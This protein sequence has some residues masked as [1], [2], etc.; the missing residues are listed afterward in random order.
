MAGVGRKSLLEGGGK[1]AHRYS[2][3]NQRRLPCAGKGGGSDLATTREGSA[4]KS[5]TKMKIV[6][7]LGND[8]RRQASQQQ[9]IA[10]SLPSALDENSGGRENS[11]AKEGGK[12]NQYKIHNR[13]ISRH[14]SPRI[15]KG[16]NR[17]ML[18]MKISGALR[19]PFTVAYYERVIIE[20]I[21]RGGNLSGVSARHG[22]EPS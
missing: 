9:H 15:V 6:E 13:A 18:T 2:S 16:G 14:V 4:K 10:R 17:S 19:I 1:A 5:T 8:I 11:G 22:L 3:S 7:K 20:R 12:R 21:S